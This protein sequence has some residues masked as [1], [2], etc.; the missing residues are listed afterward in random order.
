MNFKGPHVDYVTMHARTTMNNAMKAFITAIAAMGVLRFTLGM[1]GLPD[2][3]VK[4]F[5]M[6]AVMIAG[7]IYF[8]VTTQTHKERLKDSFLLVVPYMTIEVLALGYTW[9]SGRQTIFQAREYSMGYPI[10]WHTIGH[11]IGG[12]TWEPLLVFLQME[13][14]WWLYSRIRSQSNAID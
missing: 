3:T 9:A 11:L 7:I 8:A 14:V 4:Y 10:A 2:A 12:V 1:S 13:I 6:T 5:S